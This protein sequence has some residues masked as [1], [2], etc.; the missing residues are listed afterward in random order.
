MCCFFVALLAFGPRLAFLVLWILPGG[1]AKIDAAFD[2]FVIALIGWIFLPWTTLLY[3]IFFPLEGLN[4][5]WVGIGAVVD[6]AGWMG[7]LRQR[8]QVPYYAGP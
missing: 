1:Q 4:W 5:I 7:T 6:V 8:N 3:A 2:H